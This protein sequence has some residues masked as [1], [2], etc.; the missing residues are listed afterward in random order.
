MLVDTHCHLDF[1]NFK[2]DRRLVV[3]RARQAG[4]SHILN[5]GVDVNSSREAIKLANT[6]PE[7][8][9]VVGVHPNDAPLWNDSSLDDLRQMVKDPKVVA[10]GEIGLDYYRDRAPREVQRRVFRLQLELATEVSLPVVIH[11]RNKSTDDRSATLD[12]LEIL[13][14]WCSQLVKRKHS[15]AER[16][17]VLHSYSGSLETARQALD[18]NFKIG[19]SGPV[20]F[21]KAEMLREVVANL[22]LEDLLLETDAPFLT[23]HPHRGERNE[24]AYVRLVAEVIAQIRNLSFEDVADISTKNAKHLFQWL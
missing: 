3:D 18:L 16:P 21:R 10:L 19:I 2:R 7:V 4:L 11:M 6:Y 24:P 17:G 5:P 1:K 8:Y 9:A 22:P 13:V 20:T 12:M 15:L 14:G 23:P